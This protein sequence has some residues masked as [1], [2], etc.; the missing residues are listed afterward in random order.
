MNEIQKILEATLPF[1]KTLLYDYGEFYPLAAVVN[2]D[3]K[4]EQILEFDGNNIKFPK[5]VSVLEN[6]KKELNSKSENFIAVAIFYEVRLIEKNIDAIAVFVEDK[7]E[8]SAYT[9]YYPYKIEQ[10]E[11][12]FCDS[13]KTLQS[14]EIFIN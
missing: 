10:N 4:V 3:K 9:F 1:V 2:I 8:N 13:W 11:F 14:K 12:K 5:S 7:L 6:L